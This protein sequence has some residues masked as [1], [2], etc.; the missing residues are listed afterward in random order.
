MTGYLAELPYA[1]PAFRGAREEPAAK[2][3]PRIGRRIQ[4]DPLGIPLHDPR[5]AVVRQGLARYPSAPRHRSEHRPCADL[6]RRQP[7]AKAQVLTVNA[8]TP[9]ERAL[10]CFQRSILAR[11]S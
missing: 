10:A 2:A 8:M 7:V 5:R 4:P 11:D 6:R 3:V 9:L 1:R